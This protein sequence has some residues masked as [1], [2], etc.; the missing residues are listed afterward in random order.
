GDLGGN[1]PSNPTETQCCSSC[2]CRFTVHDNDTGCFYTYDTCI[3]SG[4][5]IGDA[6]CYCLTYLRGDCVNDC[7]VA[8]SCGNRIACPTDPRITCC[9]T[10]ATNRCAPRTANRPAGNGRPGL[11]VQTQI[12]H[13]NRAFPL[14]MININEHNPAISF[15]R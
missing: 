3:S 11:I 9:D 4:A 5:T 1:S 13:D 6:R 15:L 8:C 10:P 2:C 7:R 14:T 12:Q